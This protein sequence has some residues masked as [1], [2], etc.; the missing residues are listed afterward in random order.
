MKC[1][2]RPAPVY[3][4]HVRKI[5]ARR[6]GR[7]PGGAVPS[8]HADGPPRWTP[9]FS[10]RTRDGAQICRR[11]R[12][13]RIWPSSRTA[14]SC[15]SFGSAGAGYSRSLAPRSARRWSL[16]VRWPGR[17]VSRSAS[18]VE[19]PLR[20]AR[21]CYDHLAGQVAVGM[22]HAMVAGGVLRP[23]GHEYQVLS[24]GARLF[25]ELGIDLSTLGR[26][27]RKLTR[28][29]LDWTER[30]PHTRRGA[31]RRMLTRCISARWVTQLSRTRAVRITDRGS[32]AL[33][34]FMGLDVSSIREG[35]LH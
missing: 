5:S 22:A 1:S 17:G 30:E 18:K 16:L 33:R 14:G 12:P 32:R 28:Q 27:R 21:T 13:V 2:A 10:G 15:R 26:N 9:P 31:R 11:K 4:G 35:P 34:E 29:C 25:N 7:T 8:R 19:K 23:Y 20:F 24:P 3:F 6:S